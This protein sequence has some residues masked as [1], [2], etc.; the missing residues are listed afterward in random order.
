MPQQAFMDDTW[1]EEQ[2]VVALRQPVRDVDDESLEVLEAV[3]LAAGLRAASAAV[4]DG[5][6]VP[7]VAGGATVGR[8]LRLHSFDVNF[9]P[10]QA[11][12]DSLRGVDPYDGHGSHVASQ[13]VG[14]A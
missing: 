3:R 11:D 14:T 5:G 1:A 12:D 4:A 13:Q 10:P 9:S 8:H 7:D 6:I 2:Q